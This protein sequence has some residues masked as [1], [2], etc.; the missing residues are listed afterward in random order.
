[1]HR[2]S[3]EFF[4]E[5]E[6]IMC[7]FIYIYLLKKFFFARN[8]HIHNSKAIFTSIKPSQYR[9]FLA[10]LE[11]VCHLM[12]YSPFLWFNPC[13]PKL[14]LLK[15]LVEPRQF[16]AFQHKI[17]QLHRKTLNI[18]KARRTS[19]FAWIQKGN[20]VIEVFSW[21]ASRSCKICRKI[22][23]SEFLFMIDLRTTLWN[24]IIQH[25][26]SNSYSEAATG[27]VL[28]KKFFLKILQHSQENTCVGLSS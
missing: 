12:W 8:S 22:L 9:V 7:R 6:Q 19:C 4:S 16:L 28:W 27:G 11:P 1:M 14:E 10:M 17:L 25:S 2:K 15:E 13:C 21:S 3:T 18:Q 5:L 24:E 26:I 20:S 23:R